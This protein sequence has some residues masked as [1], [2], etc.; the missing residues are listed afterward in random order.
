MT[1]ESLTNRVEREKPLRITRFTEPEKGIGFAYLSLPGAEYNTPY[2]W[3]NLIQKADIFKM[4]L[5]RR[6]Y[7]T[8]EN[9]VHDLLNE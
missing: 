9:I 7:R 8:A 6:Q 3:C 2:D 4:C 1:A 5:N